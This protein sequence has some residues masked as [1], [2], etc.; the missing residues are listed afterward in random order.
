MTLRDLYKRPIDRRIDPVAT[1]S[2]LD[3]AY[4]HREIE[5]YFF[6]DTLYDHLHNF[7]NKLTAG[8]EGRTGVWIN[9]YYGSGKSHFLKYIYYCLSEDFGEEALDHFETS[10]SNYE[11][12]PLEQPVTEGE[13]RQI[14]SALDGMTVDPI[15]FN[16]KT[17]ADDDVDERSVTRVFYNRLNAFR[18]YNKSNLQIAR[19]EKMLDQQGKLG[20][21]EDAFQQR[22]GDRWTEKA[23]QS[24]GFNLDKVLDAAEE[25]ADIDR[26]SARASLEKTPSVSTEELIDEMERFLRD[27]PEDYRLVYLVDEVSQYTEGKPDLLLDLQTI[28]EQIGDRLGDRVWVVC[29]AQQALKRLVDDAKAKQQADY[30]FGKIMGRFETYLPLESQSADFIARKRVLDKNPEG[31][32]RLRE[33]F[34]EHEASIRN[35]FQRVE[36]ELY[37]GYGDREEFV[38]N[39]PFVPY[40][41]KLITEVIRAFEDADFFVSGVSSTERSL[42]GNTHEVAQACM[43]EEVGYFVPFDLF[44][45]AQIDDHLTNRARSIINNALQLDRVTRHSFAERVVKA[46]FLVSNLR[47]DQSANFPA[48]AEHVAFTL[49]DE[50]DPNWAELKRRTQEVLDYLVEQNV[51]SESE[52]KYRFLQEEEIRVK[53]EIDNKT[54]NRHDRRETLAEEVIGKTIK[55][56]RNETLE[57]T[58]IK[59]RRSVDG[60]EIDSSGDA[61]VQFTVE[62]HD[63]PDTMAIGRGKGELVF[64]LHEQFGEEERRKLYEAVQINAY[65]QD[66]LDSASG[67]RLKAMKTFQDR[68]KRILEEL[69]HWLKGALPQTKYISAQQVLSAADHNGQSAK[70]LFESIVADHLRRL[71]DK[72]DQATQYAGDRSNLRRV[73]AQS[74]TEIDGSLTEAET[75]VDSYLTMEQRPTVAEVMEHFQNDPFG[76]QDTEILHILLRLEARNEWTFQW[77]SED[78]GRETFADRAVKRGEQSSFTIHEQEDVDRELMYNAAKAVNQTIFNAASEDEEVPETTDPKELQ[79]HIRELLRRKRDE[80]T[81]DASAHRGRPFARHFEDLAQALKDVEEVRGAEQLFTT[82]VDRADDLQEK[83]DQVREVS[84]FWERN[85]PRYQEMVDFVDQYRNQKHVLSQKARTRLDK[86]STF[87]RSEDQP[88][89]GFRSALEY[90]EALQE[91]VEEQINDLRDEATDE[92]EAVIEELQEKEDELGVDGIA[93]DPEAKL[94]QLR[95]TDDLGAL[96]GELNRVNDYRANYLADI[97]S[98]A[99]QNSENGDGRDAEIVE[100]DDELSSHEL[101]TEEDVEA[102]VGDLRDKL[103]ARVRDDKIVIIK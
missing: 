78:V 31:G 52:G 87:V 95:R 48:T 47:E 89:S 26:S 43:D 100:L 72:R 19:F 59:L 40:Q 49:I 97:R 28:V 46:L 36:S 102:F 63:D 34:G 25:V 62:G 61:L 67:E 7:L 32:E 75:E 38:A 51:V 79:E 65:I 66:N 60:H 80:A 71:Y 54:I 64:C 96:E 29:T 58:T 8:T 69:R 93:P 27:K 18:G 15:M 5:E 90:F 10:L 76:W 82:V 2:E 6:T 94:D 68:G 50:A 91:D 41:F 56:S 53:K 12:S 20:A 83:V 57:G 99:Q 39:Y 92:Y 77:N 88:Q 84:D 23:N 9:G 42:I 81:R 30:S 73:A 74:Q 13:V 33:Y 21:F 11:G 98:A 44:Y 17:V 24:V 70:A 37:S 1:V 4:V 103:L 101:E 14:R 22:T 45:N 55:W 85:G 3:E 35:Q 86:L 16:I